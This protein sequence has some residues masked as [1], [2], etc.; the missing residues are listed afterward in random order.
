MVR[1]LPLL[2]VA[3]YLSHRPR[4]QLSLCAKKLLKVIRVSL[5]YI[6]PSVSLRYA[7]DSLTTGGKETR[8]M[9]GDGFRKGSGVGV[10]RPARFHTHGS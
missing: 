10:R 1:S 2:C 4:P 7:G 9:R 6:E 5:R 8:G 3:V